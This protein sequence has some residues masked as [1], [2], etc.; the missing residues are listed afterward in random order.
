MALDDYLELP[1]SAIGVYLA[2]FERYGR[3]SVHM[4]LQELMVRFIKTH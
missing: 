4:L 3:S 1:R 2:I